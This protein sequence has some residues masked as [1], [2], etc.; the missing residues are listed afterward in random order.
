MRSQRHSGA[1]LIEDALALG[2]RTNAL[3]FAVEMVFRDLHRLCRSMTRT[4]ID[5]AMKAGLRRLGG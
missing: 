3:Q 4:E 5:K 1:D 2:S